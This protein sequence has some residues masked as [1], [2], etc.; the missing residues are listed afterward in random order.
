[1]E[2]LTNEKNANPHKGRRGKGRKVLEVPGVDVGKRITS[3]MKRRGIT[4]YTLAQLLDVH[5]KT[6]GNWK[7]GK[8]KP[9]VFKMALLWD[10]LRLTEEEMGFSKNYI[11]ES[12]GLTPPE[13]VSPEKG[14][15]NRPEGQAAEPPKTQQEVV[16]DAFSALEHEIEKLGT[17]FIKIFLEINTAHLNS[18]ISGIQT[19][20]REV[21]ELHEKS[22][23][24]FKNWG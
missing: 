16:L 24:I 15:D 12:A 22:E 17:Q 23:K 4:E 11:Y 7:S 3:A 20:Y 14:N 21:M 1:M 6:V 19:I 2:M 5:P 9:E 8:N 13:E 10:K 18:Q